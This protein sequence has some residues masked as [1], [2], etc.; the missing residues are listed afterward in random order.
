MTNTVTLPSADYTSLHP[1]SEA[2]EFTESVGRILGLARI[3]PK[4]DNLFI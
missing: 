4:A 3:A 1:R 2:D